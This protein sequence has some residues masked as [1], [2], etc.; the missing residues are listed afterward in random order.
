[1]RELAWR[2]VL[3]HAL[4]VRGAY[5]RRLMPD[6]QAGGAYRRSMSLRILSR[7]ARGDLSS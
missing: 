3:V 5:M 2:G 6:V 4:A 1:M 7:C